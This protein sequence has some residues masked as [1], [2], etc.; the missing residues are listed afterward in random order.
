VAF[1]GNCLVFRTEIMELHGQWADALTEAQK[2]RDLLLQP[3]AKPFAGAAVYEIA[4]LHR[5]R[6]EFA[7]AEEAYR[8]ASQMGHAHMPGLARMR[9]AQ[10]HADQA[11]GAIRRQRD[12]ARELNVRADV[13][14]AFV[15]IM[16]A[17]GDVD[18]ARDGAQELGEIAAQ[19][20]APILDAVASEARGAVLLAG[21]DAR[22]A[23]Q[24]LRRASGLWRDLDAPYDVARVRVQIARACRAL[25]DPESAG[26]EL[27]AARRAFKELG[28]AP[29][30]AALDARPNAASGLSAREVEVL[31]LVAA[32]KSNRAIAERLVISEKTVARHVSNIFTKLGL[33]SRAAATAYAYEH[34]LK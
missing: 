34:G 6:G 16:L 20:R 7:R 15:E 5:L 32:G 19:L 14:P 9:L 3:P 8:Q 31:R 28:A 17:T 10:G 33:S 25:G 30:L 2:A 21:G 1:R 26:L 23:L 22:A 12:E 24:A 27:D 4:E 29:D 13:L 11:A 18:A